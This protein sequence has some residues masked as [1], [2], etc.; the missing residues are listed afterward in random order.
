MR[1]FMFVYMWVYSNVLIRACVL[2]YICLYRVCA[3]VRARTAYVHAH[4][5]THACMRARVCVCDISYVCLRECM[6]M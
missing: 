5:R 4:T 1:T 3:C 6:R 2:V